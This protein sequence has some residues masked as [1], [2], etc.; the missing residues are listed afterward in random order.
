MEK[1]FDMP[2]LTLLDI[3]K[4]NGSDAMVGLIDET[5]KAHPEIMQVN[6][7]T[8]K[9]YQYRTLVRA[10]LGRTTGSFRAA[11]AGTAAIKHTYENR[12]VETY[13]L[14]PRIEVDKAVAD[15]AE[16]GAQAVIATETEGAMEGEMQGLAAQFYY[17][18]GAGG[19]SE[20]FPGLIQAYD[21]TNMVVDA[22]GTTA[23]T[24]SSVWFVREGPKAVTWV[25]GG[26]GE[27][28]ANPLRIES[29]T[30]AAD[31]TKKYDAYV[32]TLY[33]RPGLQVGDIRAV[34][35][36]KKLTEDS[37]KGLTDALI[38]KALEKFP[39]G[40]GPNVCFMSQRSARQLQSSRTA[41]TPTGAP[42]P[43]PTFIVGIDGRN[44]PIHITEAISNTESLTL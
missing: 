12:L 24:G 10:A 27:L 33:G 7:R 16:D 41:T 30:D 37:G 35:R 29:V 2:V 6:S 8:I 3:A 38:N 9:G 26:N 42:A 32:Q 4:R 31:T 34:C 22:A 14:E 15:S 18:T 21:A 25:W 36:I 44:I 20:G 19:N 23:T 5:S 43:W 13:I 1:E 39:A 40:F 28:R 11:N 17:G